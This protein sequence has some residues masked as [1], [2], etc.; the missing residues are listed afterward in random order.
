MTQLLPSSE[1]AERAVLASVLL[2]P[3]HLQTVVGRLKPEDFY[4][5]RHRIIYQAYQE[6]GDTGAQLDL[7]S[8]QDNLERKGS[9]GKIGGMAY[10]AGLDIDLPDLSRCSHHIEIVKDRA[11]RR[12]L[13]QDGNAALAKAWDG[14]DHSAADVLR[15]VESLV[16]A[17]S[18]EVDT[19]D[20]VNFATACEMTTQD[21]EARSLGDRVGIPTGFYDLDGMCQGLAPGNLVI[22]AG[23]PGMGKTALATNIAQNVVQEGIPVLFFSL[24]MG[25]R[26]LTLRMWSSEA[27]IPFSA[28]R[29]GKMTERQ[30]KSL[31]K[32][33]NAVRDW[34]IYIDPTGSITVSEIA[35]KC[36]KVKREHG[37]GM[38]IVDYIQ[39]MRE[40]GENRVL[41]VAAITRGLKLLAKDLDVPVMALSQ[42]SRAPETRTSNHRPVLSD[43]RE[44]GAI[45]QDADQVIFVYR[46]E[47]YN[48]DDPDNKGLAEIIV[49]KNRHGATGSVELV[50]QG[51]TVQFRNYAKAAPTT[52]F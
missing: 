33:V 26:E 6:I 51:E 41:E 23:R 10:V 27:D 46:D 39:L 24:E 35:A 19:G 52:P 47:M 3:D 31:Y 21:V 22:V 20:V 15:E 34:P 11:L 38:V 18:A 28:L 50:F 48:K 42:L 4:S 12:T 32:T 13:I 14:R 45:E 8:L 25:V 17:V 44:S 9:W 16:M 1:E 36:A 7:R 2:A 40:A 43:L 5:E 30:W 49:G 37:L 29:G